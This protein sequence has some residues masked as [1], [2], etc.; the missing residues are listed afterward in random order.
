MNDHLLTLQGICMFKEE[1]KD[2]AI[3]YFACSACPVFRNPC[4]PFFF[5]CSSCLL[6][7]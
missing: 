3:P 6:F 1:I 2:F 7:N 5:I 4:Q